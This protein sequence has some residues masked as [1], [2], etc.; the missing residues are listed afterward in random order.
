M[1]AKISR[2]ADEIMLAAERPRRAGAA[3]IETQD[4]IT[5]VEE[6]ARRIQHVE[7]GFGAGEAVDQ[8]GQRATFYR[9]LRRVDHSQERIATAIVYRKEDS[10]S[11]VGA[12]LAGGGIQQNC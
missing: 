10:L 4:V 3:Q 6:I 1:Q 12:K 2:T 7:A 8:N 5:V 9:V 11:G